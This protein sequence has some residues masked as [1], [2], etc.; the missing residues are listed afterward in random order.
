MNFIV[1]TPESLSRQQDET[2]NAQSE[3]SFLHNHNPSIIQRTMNRVRQ[4]NS[5]GRKTT[6]DTALSCFGVFPALEI[7][8]DMLKSTT[9]KHTDAEELGRDL[10]DERNTCELDRVATGA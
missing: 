2:T 10:V 7:V 3:S 8:F 4:R 6:K 5:C 1:K 9:F